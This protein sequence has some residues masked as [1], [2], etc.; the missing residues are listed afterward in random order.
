M[1]FL[2]HHVKLDVPFEKK[3]CMEINVADLPDLDMENPTKHLQDIKSSGL[4]KISCQ[5]SW[6]LTDFN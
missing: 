2:N 6:L 3:I 5:H 1:V 4:I